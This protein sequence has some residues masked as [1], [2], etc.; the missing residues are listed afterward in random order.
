[1][2]VR[3]DVGLVSLKAG[4]AS[5]QLTWPG[6]RQ[7]AADCSPKTAQRSRLSSSSRT[8]KPTAMVELD[9]PR[10]SRVDRLPPA[11]FSTDTVHCGP[12]LGRAPASGGS[13][14]FASRQ[15]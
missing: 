2:N 12:Q 13:L 9:Q 8:S 5:P 1:M 14:V 3:I 7:F 15:R 11:E 6:R 4:V 10:A